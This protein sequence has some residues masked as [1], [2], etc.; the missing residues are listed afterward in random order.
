MREKSE[1]RGPPDQ[2]RRSA[3][4]SQV[5]GPSCYIL[6]PKILLFLPHTL[7]SLYSLLLSLYREERR[8]RREKKRWCVRDGG[9]ER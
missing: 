3:G 9:E 5:L 6:L 4:P 1:V 8:E 7:L 2:V